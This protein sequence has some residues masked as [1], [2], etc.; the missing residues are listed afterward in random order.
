MLKVKYYGVSVR[1][2]LLALS[3]QGTKLKMHYIWE[4]FQL[5]HDEF[6][7]R[8]TMVWLNYFLDY[9]NGTI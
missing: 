4:S 5:T 7:I 6:I 1:A 3:I 8:E 2:L 9:A